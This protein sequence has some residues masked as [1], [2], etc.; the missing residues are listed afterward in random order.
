VEVTKDV[1]VKTIPG[2]S[3]EEAV[4]AE[5]VKITREKRSTSDDFDGAG[6]VR[7]GTFNGGDQEV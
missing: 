3:P 1:P 6:G 5:V 4:D 7:G 2:A